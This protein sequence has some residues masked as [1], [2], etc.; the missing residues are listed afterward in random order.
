MHDDDDHHH[1]CEKDVTVR[2]KIEI[3]SSDAVQG[4]LRDQIGFFGG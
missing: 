3:V 4:Y 2:M 1:L